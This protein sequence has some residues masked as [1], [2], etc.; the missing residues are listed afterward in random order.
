MRRSCCRALQAGEDGQ[1]DVLQDEQVQGLLMTGYLVCASVVSQE[2]IGARQCAAAR[3]SFWGRERK[4]GFRERVERGKKG[5]STTFRNVQ[6]RWKSDNLH[7]VGLRA[8][9]AT[10]PTAAGAGRAHRAVA[11]PKVV[12][13]P[14]RSALV[15]TDVWYSFAR[16]GISNRGGDRARIRDEVR[17]WILMRSAEAASADI[18]R[19]DDDGDG[20]GGRRRNG[21]GGGAGAPSPRATAPGADIGRVAVNQERVEQLWDGACTPNLNAGTGPTPPFA[22]PPPSGFM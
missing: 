14:R 2:G 19:A 15:G 20:D 10:S 8:W 9:E 18:G 1:R 6:E 13:V 21:G 22:P 17:W 7:V 16:F 3:T 4:A 5:M 12:A 11:G